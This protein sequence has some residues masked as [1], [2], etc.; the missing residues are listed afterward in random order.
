MPIYWLSSVSKTMEFSSS[1]LIKG[2]PPQY[3][4]PQMMMAMGQ[5][6]NISDDAKI[7]EVGVQFESIMIKELLNQALGPIFENQ[8]KNVPGGNIYQGMIIDNL[9]ETIA[10]SGQMGI[11][12][13]FERELSRFK[14]NNSQPEVSESKKM[15]DKPLPKVD[16]AK[17]EPE[18]QAKPA[19]DVL[20]ADS[21]T[22]PL[23]GSVEDQAR[24]AATYRRWAAKGY[25]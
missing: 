8:M 24:L 20:E 10:R 3:R 15:D 17:A 19:T 2:V 11:S 13:V 7:K 22:Q 14:T 9:S 21:A 23:P 18:I 12:Q 1:Q 16:T 4:S 6:P 25:L 5:N